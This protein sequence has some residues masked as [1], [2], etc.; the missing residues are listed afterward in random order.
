MLMMSEQPMV[1]IGV[2]T[3]RDTHTAA[4]IDPVTGREIAFYTI[5][6]TPAGYQELIEGVAVHGRVLVW[7]VEGTRTYGVGLVRVLLAAGEVVSEADRPKR[8]LRRAGK[9]DQ[10]D[11]SRAGREALGHARITQPRQGSHRDAIAAY[12]IVRQSAVEASA[13]A[14]NQ[15]K[16]MIVTSPDEIRSLVRGRTKAATWHACEALVAPSGAS[17]ETEATVAA[18][19][20]LAK[21]IVS[22]HAE[23]DRL[24]RA[25][26]RHVA[27]WRPELLD[28]VG[29]GVITAAQVLC[30]WSHPGRFHSEAAFAMLAGVAPI[31]ASSGQTVRHRLNRRGDRQLNQALHTVARTRMRHHEPTKM[32]VARRLTEGKSRIE[33]RRC[34]KRYIARELFRLL[35]HTPVAV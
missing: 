28:R 16:A 26:H 4:V 1:V 20:T 12:L 7:A 15:L 13:I 21:R 34:I 10:I 8:P 18:M 25:I 14:Q 17:I 2:D 22:L 3:H 19:V 32:Y 30:A 5:P 29:V 6:T 31:P 24:E 23:A 11:A 35:E 9:N 27:V 33:I